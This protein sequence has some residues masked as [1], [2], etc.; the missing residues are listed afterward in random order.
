VQIVQREGELREATS[1]VGSA[2]RSSSAKAIAAL[3][4]ASVAG[5]E[6]VP[7]RV[8]RETDWKAQKVRVFDATDGTMIAEEAASEGRAGDDPRRRRRSAA[9]R[10]EGRRDRR[11]PAATKRK[12]LRSPDELER[13]I[14][15]TL[16]DEGACEGYLFATLQSGARAPDRVGG[17]GADARRTRPSERRS[18]G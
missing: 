7:L 4:D 11:E 1:A 16:T 6:K 8:W 18:G 10:A 3:K 12:L 14:L 15:A 2:V 17:A 9:H 5:V 13:L